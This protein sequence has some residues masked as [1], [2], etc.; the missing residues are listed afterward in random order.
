[1][2]RVLLTETRRYLPNSYL[3]TGSARID[4]CLE[5]NCH[6]FF[7]LITDNSKRLAGWDIVIFTCARRLTGKH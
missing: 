6:Q 7:S 2:P 1:M 5:Y 4:C 3:A